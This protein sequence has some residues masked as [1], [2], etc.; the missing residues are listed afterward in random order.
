MLFNS[1]HF[2]LFLPIVIALY[3]LL[4]H[5]FRWIL[6]FIASCYFYMALI[7]LYIFILFFI[8]LIDY[9]AALIIERL[10]GR[11][12][13]LFLV[14][15]IIAN[16]G[17]LAFFKYF[18]FANENLTGLLGCFGKHNPIGHINI[19]LPIGLSFHTFQSMA[20]TIEVYRGKQKAE[21]HIGYFANYVLF[22]PQ[23]VAGPIERYNRLGKQLR[24]EH[25]FSYDNFAKGFRLILFGFFAKMAIADNLAVVVN[26]VY[27]TPEQYSSV[28]VL[29]AIVFFSFQIYAD[30]F[31]YSLIAMGAAK[32][33][34]IDL[35][36][37]FRTPYLA[38]SINEFWTRWHISLTSWFRDYLYIP[39]GGNRVTVFRWTLNIIIVFAI[40]GLW[41]GASWTFV[42]WGLLH[43]TLY[44]VERA[45]NKIFKITTENQHVIFN[46][47]R[48]IKTFMVVSVIW[49]FFRAESLGKVKQIVKA[50]VHNRHVVDDLKIDYKIWGLLLFFILFDVVLF[51][52]RVDTW[53]GTKA[54]VIRWS[55]Y[56]VLLFAVMALGGVE[57]IPFIYF[58][59]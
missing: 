32:L 36:E 5:R 34:G 43:G 26:K 41:H 58:Q 11:L 52:K 23:M 47:F 27:T 10:D 35:M 57:N 51:N 21:R 49:I 6:I 15:S 22:F 29:T 28:S 25:S 50:V 54:I 1:L 8:I 55:V 44:L 13:K 19:I 46:G 37:N 56:A 14:I 39:L 17:L 30:F 24:E 33:M 4:P 45:S 3:Y 38:K 59:F 31:G 2:L 20:Y 42:I 12:R 18:N 40:S 7:P 53:L 16:V 48:I 9:S